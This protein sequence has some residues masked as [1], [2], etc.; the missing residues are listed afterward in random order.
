MLAEPLQYP[1][2]LERKREHRSWH[3]RGRF[4]RH[5][6]GGHVLKG[7]RILNRKSGPRISNTK[8]R[9]RSARIENHG[10]RAS[11]HRRMSHQTIRLNS[12]FG[13]Q[14]VGSE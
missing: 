5:R 1:G 10:R 12:G 2:G 9:S 7:D 8:A 13:N 3:D 4:S 11:R 14:P 6:L